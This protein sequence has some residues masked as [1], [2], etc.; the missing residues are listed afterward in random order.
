[1]KLVYTG[2]ESSGKSLL[3]AKRVQDLIWRNRKWHKKYG[4]VRKL[5]SNLKF[6]DEFYELNKA[7]IEYWY[8]YKDL[9]TKTGMD[10][11]WDEISSDFS[12]LKK[13]PLPKKVNRWLRQGAKQG[14]HIYST[15]Q[16]LHDLH[17][18]FRRRTFE[19]YE[20]KKAFG[21]RRGGDNLPPVK[22]IWG[23]CVTRQLKIRPYNELKPEYLGL[24]PGFFF[25][26][27]KDCLLFDTHQIIAESIEPALEHYERFCLDPSCRFHKTPM[28][29]HR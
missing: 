22:R 14:V 27:K 16:E 7:Y 9:L 8:D 15:A 25:I 24:L 20:V 18:D 28:V 2:I 6:S 10:V 17:L 5:W 1:M 21:S 29:S 19:A 12:A 13:E 3:L 4:F 26:S 11:I 23:V